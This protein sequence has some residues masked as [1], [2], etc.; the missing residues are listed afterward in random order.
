M[1][2]FGIGGLAESL[3]HA[4]EVDRENARLALDFVNL[5]LFCFSSRYLI[6]LGSVFPIFLKAIH[7]SMV[8]GDSYNSL[9]VFKRTKHE[10]L[11]GQ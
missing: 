4:A 7:L 9:I 1:I 5:F 3:R 10:F 11:I 6:I 8:S 2:L